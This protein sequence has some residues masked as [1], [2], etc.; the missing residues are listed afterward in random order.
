VVVLCAALLVKLAC[1]AEVTSPEPTSDEKAKQCLMQQRHRVSKS[2]TLHHDL[3][4]HAKVPHSSQSSGGDRRDSSPKSH[5]KKTL[6][7]HSKAQGGKMTS[8]SSKHHL[9]HKDKKQA[10]KGSVALV[11]KGDKDAGKPQKFSGSQGESS[12]H[13]HHKK[14][15]HKSIKESAEPSLAQ[16]SANKS[17]VPDL[18]EL[19]PEPVL[20]LA[21]KLFKTEGAIRGAV[22]NSVVVSVTHAGVPMS[23]RMNKYDDATQR[24][25]TEG[26]WFSYD[27]DTL[28]DAHENPQDVMNMI[29]VGGNY[30]VVTIAAMKKYAK[31]LRVVT[32]EPIPT[33]FFFLKWNLHI[34]GVPE[35]DQANWDANKGTPG[36][37]ALN[38][39]S[40]DVAGENL[41]FCSYPWSSMN[42]KMCDCP[43]GEDN[44][45]IVPSVAVNDLVAMFGSDPI[46]MVKMDCEGCEF[47]S[48]PALG[49]KDISKRVRRLAGELH[50]PDKNLEEIACR[51]DDGRLLTKCQQGQ[52]GKDDIE[53]GV[54]LSC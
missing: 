50:L 3:Q 52:K 27:L 4:T 12:H 35:I 18:K 10:A 15:H 31:N 6:T 54:K 20:A 13:K 17:R 48:L 8:I 32:V 30:G 39:G 28:G 22:E 16:V 49:K 25:G 14:R 2:D 7:K 29:D 51:W 37:L 41:H 45:H 5:V 24:L 26:T 33:T 1:S 38:S 43:E 23:L 42:S 9:Q 11:Q 19:L 47:K 21:W 34:N 36:V 53:C 46:A 40:S 44:C